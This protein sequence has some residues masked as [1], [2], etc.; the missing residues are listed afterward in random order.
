MRFVM[1]SNLYQ[2]NQYH[3]SFK[4]DAFQEKP[5]YN[6]GILP[7]ITRQVLVSSVSE[8]GGITIDGIPVNTVSRQ[9]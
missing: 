2:N 9:K 5:D 7:V 6:A 8:D 1:I 4:H 3:L